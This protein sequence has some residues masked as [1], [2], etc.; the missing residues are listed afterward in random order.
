[1]NNA[2][3]SAMAQAGNQTLNNSS[4]SINSAFGDSFSLAGPIFLVVWAVLLVFIISLARERRYFQV[5][6]DAFGDVALSVYYFVHGVVFLVAIAALMSPAYLFATANSS[7][8]QA[9]GKYV[10]GALVAYIVITGVGYLAKQYVHDPIR[11]NVAEVIP[12]DWE[13][14]ETEEPDEGGEPADD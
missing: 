8:Q 9:V 13:P 4:T 11:E 14:D 12:E 6:V 1:M 3:V 10:G 7:T 2:I 5:L